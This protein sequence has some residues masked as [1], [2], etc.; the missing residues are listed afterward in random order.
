MCSKYSGYSGGTVLV[1]HIST[2]AHLQV[3]D[4]MFDHVGRVTTAFCVDWALTGVPVSTLRHAVWTRCPDPVPY[5]WLPGT[6]EK[7]TTSAGARPPQNSRTLGLTRHLPWTSPGRERCSHG[8]GTP[9][10]TTAAA[11]GAGESFDALEE[12]V[13]ASSQYPA[14]AHE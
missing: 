7:Q 2:E 8:A 14:E 12:P 3:I 6:G 9:E 5:A 4:E 11:D 10:H 1:L 13:L